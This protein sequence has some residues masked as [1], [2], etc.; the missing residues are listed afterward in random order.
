MDAGDF[1][2]TGRRVGGADIEIDTIPAVA[3]LA[4]ELL[5]YLE[6]NPELVHDDSVI[7]YGWSPVRLTPYDDVL[8][9][10]VPNVVT[11][12]RTDVTADLSTVLWLRAQ[13][14]WL[15]EKTGL[16]L[17]E[18]SYLDDVMVAQGWRTSE[19]RHM[20]RHR[21]R[22]LIAADEITDEAADDKG[23][24]SPLPSWELLRV[25]LPLA[26]CLW[27]PEGSTAI[28]DEQQILEVRDGSKIGNLLPSNL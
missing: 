6:Q 18:L 9:A 22:W 27:L 8:V 15:A 2:T 23:T 14:W 26:Y 5:S 10:Q 11:N 19:R 24:W 16:E 12:P 25:A 17:E 20:R 13:Q 3:F 21:G 4:D 1:T 7:D 28:V